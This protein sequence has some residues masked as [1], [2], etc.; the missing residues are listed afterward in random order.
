MYSI[1]FLRSGYGEIL[2]SELF[3]EYSTC[4]ERPS[5]FRKG[6]GLYFYLNSQFSRGFSD[7]LNGFTFQYLQSGS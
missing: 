4:P 7:L 6:T 5:D 3:R 2:E 1:V